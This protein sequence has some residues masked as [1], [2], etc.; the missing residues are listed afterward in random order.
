MYFKYIYI[1]EYWISKI[2]FG[3]GKVSY[4][5]L[6]IWSGLNCLTKGLKNSII[7][8]NYSLV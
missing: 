8:N 6:T 5:S 2:K 1:Y 4:H 7:T 3:Y